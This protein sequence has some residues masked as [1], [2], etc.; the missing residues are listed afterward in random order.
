MDPTEKSPEKY[1]YL[2]RGWDDVEKVPVKEYP[3]FFRIRD[4]RPVPLE[5]GAAPL[6]PTVADSAATEQ[7]PSQQG[8]VPEAPAPKPGPPTNPAGTAE[9]AQQPPV[10]TGPQPPAPPDESRKQQV[11]KDKALC[12]PLKVLRDISYKDDEV[13]DILDLMGRLADADCGY[14]DLLMW[15][16]MADGPEALNKVCKAVMAGTLVE[17]LAIG[18]LVSKKVFGSVLDDDRLERFVKLKLACSDRV[19]AMLEVMG[20]FSK[21]APLPAAKAPPA[22]AVQVNL[23]QVMSGG[24]QDIQQ[25][26]S[27]KKEGADVSFDLF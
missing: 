10:L 11:N 22:A 3:K 4:G 17:N 2:V 8:G 7:A 18:Q 15:L 6:P 24:K 26:L 5:G 1:I 16:Y 19:A 27:Q 25:K 12:Y 23:Q 14:V 13:R 21:V 9:P 20:R